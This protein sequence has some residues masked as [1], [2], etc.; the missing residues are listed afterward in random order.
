M[1]LKTKLRPVYHQLRCRFLGDDWQQ[2]IRP[3]TWY[4]LPFWIKETIAEDWRFY[5]R[6]GR[7]LSLSRIWGLWSP[8]LNQPIFIIG[9]P[10]SGTTFLG[11]CLGT[12][13]Q[14]SYHFEPIL[15][16]AATRYVYQGLW[17]DKFARWFYRTVYQWLMRIHFD[18]DLC[19]AE[20]TPQISLIIPFLRRTFPQARFIHII[21][22]G[23]DAALSLSKK[24]WYSNRMNGSGAK[25]PDGYPFGSK[26]RFWV[27]PERIAEY[28][29]TNDIHRCIWLWRRYLEIILAAVPRL[30]PAQYH[31]L[32]YESLVQNPE[33]EA[34][35]L[36]DFLG[37]TQ[38]E[39]RTN[40]K[41]TFIAQ[42]N[43]NSVGN[44]SRQ[45]TSQ[46][47][48]VMEQEADS[49]LKNLNYITK[50]AV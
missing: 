6:S 9:A 38:P 16:K 13:P 20:K 33:L 30:D 41:Q 45:L 4:N 24:P 47:I 19:F 21:R 14:I 35:R 36:I 5:Q 18:A 11:E 22:D 49:L 17:S 34:Q 37:I 28:E 43:P 2:Q 50:S 8:N 29:S 25:E 23:R 32:R 48:D 27:E 12:N 7:S 10:R 44:W 15:T 39:A 3:I 42:A 46:Q 26:A 31:E 1:N 40:L